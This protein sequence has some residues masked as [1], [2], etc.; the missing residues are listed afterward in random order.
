MSYIISQHIRNSLYWIIPFIPSNS[1]FSRTP[2]QHTHTH[3]VIIS[4]GYTSSRPGSLA[5]LPHHKSQRQFTGR[6]LPSAFRAAQPLYAQMT[7]PL[8][9][10]KINCGTIIVPLY[11]HHCG[12][13]SGMFYCLRMGVWEMYWGRVFVDSIWICS[14]KNGMVLCWS[15]NCLPLV[16]VFW[17]W[18]LG[19]NV[20]PKVDFP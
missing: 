4:V 6:F 15:G 2:P 19:K 8:T 18:C 10:R 7:P 5:K 1:T 3:R 14:E 13:S 16:M 11:Q 12:H 17:N 9:A 20:R